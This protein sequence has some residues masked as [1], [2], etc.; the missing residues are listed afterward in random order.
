MKIAFLLSVFVSLAVLVAISFPPSRA[1]LLVALGRT[2][3][4]AV[5]LLAFLLPPV[6]FL[7]GALAI[8]FG[9]AIRWL[10]TTFGVFLTLFFLAASVTCVLARFHPSSAV[11][12]GG[13]LVLKLVVA[14]EGLM[15]G[16]LTWLALFLLFTASVAVLTG[17]DI[18]TDLENLYRRMRTRP[19]RAR[20]V[21]LKTIEPI[22]EPPANPWV[23]QETVPVK[24]EPE[25]TVLYHDSPRPEPFR[26]TA[27]DDDPVKTPP[28]QKLRVQT[29]AQIQVQPEPGEKDETAYALPD[30][31]CLK[32]PVPGERT[33]QSAR[34][35][36]ERGAILVE[37]LGDFGIEC[38]LEST[39]CAGPVLTRYELTPGLGVK[40][41][42]IVNMADDLAL[43]LAA[44]RIRIL[45]PIPGKGTV[46]IE[47]PNKNPEMVYLREV[48]VSVEN[49]RIPVALGKNAEGKPLVVDIADMPH[50]LI[51]GA[52]GS[53]KSICIH[54]IL[55][56]ILMT[57]TPSQV[58]LALVD[59][60]MLELSIYE[61]VPHLW[62]PVVLNPQRAK[63][64]LDRLVREMEDRYA[65]LTRQGVRSIDEY[66]GN[67]RS[68]FLADRAGRGN[69]DSSE[70]PDTMP[71]IVAVIDELADLRMVLG[72]DI[73]QPIAR[74]AQKARAVG[75]HLVVATQRPSVDVITGMIKA[76][77]P[78][79][80]AFNVKSKTDSRT[81]LDMNGAEKLLGQGDML[82]MPAGA[83]DPVRVHGSFVSSREIKELVVFWKAQPHMPYDYEPGDDEQ[84]GSDVTGDLS[85]DD[86][87]LE[88]A[89]RVVVTYQRGSASLLQRRLKVGYTRAARLLEMLEQTGV[90][91]PYCGSKAREVLQKPDS[92]PVLPDDEQEMR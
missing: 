53:G 44:K 2:L 69:E 24:T 26:A 19:G 82:F 78:S 3:R 63:A 49:E 62:A 46:G 20:P 54:S 60:K 39:V 34:E 73:E 45:A 80:I 51:A 6:L 40:V 8:G 33:R 41:N 83:P 35:I 72:N 31:E 58:R 43:A 38:R 37:K 90:V 47:V 25:V 30:I 88:E 87:L 76:N 55:T 23:R 4:D 16:V 68:A 17:W 64:L 14:L 79:R 85:L 7:L 36:Q 15:G 13:I 89:R 70:T 57:R 81:I 74:L 61:G 56:S 84:N 52:T 71:S 86:P 48:L 21:A 11:F 28:R 77:F 27:G 1:G 32:M 75:I 65:L 10:R 29:K 9:F 67:I 18:G 12:P 66:N 92:G 91:G 50:L 5:G 42:R 59:P 22:P